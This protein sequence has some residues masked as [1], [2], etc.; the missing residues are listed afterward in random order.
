MLAMLK[1]CVSTKHG[2]TSGSTISTS[3][4][5]S[6]SK[7][8]YCH[9]VFLQPTSSPSCSVFRRY[10]RSIYSTTGHSHPPRRSLVRILPVLCQLV[11]VYSLLV[12]STSVL[13]LGWLSNLVYFALLS[14]TPTPTTSRSSRPVERNFCSGSSAKLW[15]QDYR[16]R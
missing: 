6:N 7:C 4:Q 8:V 3:S 14:S 15:H 12:S 2:A 11:Y 16:P 13:G 1:Y 10:F 5:P 9:R